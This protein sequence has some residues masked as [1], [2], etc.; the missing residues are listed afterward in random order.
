MARF[1]QSCL[2]ADIWLM[3]ECC[4]TIPDRSKGQPKQLRDAIGWLRATQGGSE[5]LS[6]ARFILDI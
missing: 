4:H 6:V 3:P 1:N 2:T 5:W